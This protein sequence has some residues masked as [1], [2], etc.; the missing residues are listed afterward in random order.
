M[1]HAQ[2]GVEQHYMRLLLAED[3][4]KVSDFVAR[5]LRAERFAVDLAYDGQSA[6]EFAASFQYDAVILDLML[7][8]LS[9]TEV[10]KRIRHQT[11]DVPVLI[12]T[13]KDD[14]A[15]KVENFE[16]GACLR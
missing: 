7:P 6:C 14:T 8:V 11:P 10:L 2:V 4:R 15:T 16:A 9:G 1:C 13:A 3:D 5:G 12:L